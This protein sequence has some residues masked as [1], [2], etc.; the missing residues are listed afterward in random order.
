MC[1]NGKSLMPSTPQDLDLLHD[2]E[3]L[4]RCLLESI[5]LKLGE[6]G[7]DWDKALAFT[8]IFSTKSYLKI[9][10]IFATEEIS[11]F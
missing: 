1:E 5:D 2:V 9:L 8:T 6:Y 11:G 3:L 7:L 4:G 10:R